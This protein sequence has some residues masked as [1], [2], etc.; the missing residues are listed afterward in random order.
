[1]VRMEALNFEISSDINSISSAV[2]GVMQYLDGSCVNIDE[3]AIFDIRVI[4]NELLINSIIHGN[5]KNLDKKIMI[6]VGVSGKGY[7]FVFV[8]DEG[9]GYDFKR[10]LNRE[11]PH[12]SLSEMKEYGR[13]VLI[14]ESL[15]DRIKFNKKGNK[16]IVL[17]KI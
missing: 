13:G 8:E 10:F 17:K 16:V 15:C 2:S 7:F 5:K 14:I 3:C 11:T 9:K 1:M 12:Q 6:R 4:L